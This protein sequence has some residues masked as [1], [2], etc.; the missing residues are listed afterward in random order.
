MKSRILNTNID[1][2]TLEEATQKLN[3]FLENEKNHI[4]ITPN[5]EIII[6]A[7]KDKELLK[8]INNADL[9]V[10]DGIGVVI[11]SMFTKRK[12]KQ[13]VAGIDLIINF[14]ENLEKEITI[15][16]FGGKDGVAEI[17]KK[18]LEKKYSKLKVVG[19]NNGYFDKEK[20]KN[21]IEEIKEKKPDV[22][23]VGLGAPRQEKW[24]NK[25]KDLPVKISIGVGGSIDVMSGKIKRAPDIFIKLNLE[26][27]YRLLKEPKRIKRMGALPI[28]IF[29]VI[30]GE[31]D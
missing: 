9:V 29:K 3:Y 31:K 23:L 17:A 28:F 5:P 21:I 11:A 8:I 26:W 2:V 6:K 30:I 4:V 7:N 13:R 25:N 10:P 12:L 15:Y 16:I 20:E 27:F 14:F 24:I 22:L 18:N 19:Y 1:M